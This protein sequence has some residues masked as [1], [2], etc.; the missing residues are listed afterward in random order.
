[1]GNI[2]NG[3]RSVGFVDGSP[4]LYGEDIFKLMDS[5]GIPLQDIVIAI[6]ERKAVLDLCGF[7]RA[8]KSSGSYSNDKL[9]M[10]V[11]SQERLH[12]VCAKMV[13]A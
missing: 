8:A 11:L 2:L 1:M 12:E 9:K 6:R 13:K 3:I 4:V 7:I 10:I 5:K